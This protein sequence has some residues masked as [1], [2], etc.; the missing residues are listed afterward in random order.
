MTDPVFDLQGLGLS[1]GRHAAVRDVDLRIR[2]HE[3][4][5]LIGANGCGKST[6]LRGLS[7]QMAPSAGSIAFRGEV[8]ARLRAKPYAREVALLPQTP[9]V[10]EG[11]TV[12]ELVAR[13]RHPHRQWW[14]SPAPGDDEAVARALRLLRLEDVAQRRVD[15]LSGGQ[16]QRAWIALV[17]AQDTPVM[18][19]DEPT[20]ALD[21]AHQVDLLD[22]L[23]GL[24]RPDGTRTT[25]VAVL[26]ELNLA[27]RVAD[28]VVAM[29]DGRVV[30]TG[31]PEEVLTPDR[32]RE[33]FDLRAEVIADPAEGHPV[34]LPRA[35][36]DGPAAASPAP[37]D[38]P[39]ERS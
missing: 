27:A 7:R 23:H 5:V 32:L 20:A 14:G 1:Y 37:P 36:A 3:T 22:L 16:R 13:G 4:T 18:L 35:R 30:A 31:T 6:L 15:E 2:P 11:L 25:V 39:Q 19:L 24:R 33:I 29:A 12:T 38:P 9:V 34:I 10:P 17:L 28:R 8:L 21:L 26:H